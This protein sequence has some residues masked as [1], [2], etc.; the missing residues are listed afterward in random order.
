MKKRR[1]TV[2][3]FMV[4]LAVLVAGA[5]LFNEEGS[6]QADGKKW[7]RRYNGP[8]NSGDGAYAI[9]VDRSGNVYVT[10]Y[11]VGLGT[12]RD[13]ATIKYS[14]TGKQLWVKRYNGPGNGDDYAYAIAVDRSG[15]VYVTGYSTGSGTG[16]DYAT[17]KYSS[18]GK[19]LWV[20]RYNGPGNNGDYAFAMAVDSSGNV[21]V[22]GYSVGSGTYRDYATIKY[23]STGK[24]LWVKR[25]NGPGNGDDYAFAVAVD[26]SNNVYVT[27]YSTGSGT[28]YDYATIKY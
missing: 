12:Y 24:Q 18:S 19:E 5:V 3:F 22:T 16:Y 9:A 2:R 17:I 28:G 7:V 23:S 27:G 8:G 26:S 10:G 15:N 6:A 20:K 14:S 1:V 13:Y 21:Y 11:S 4:L 25:Y